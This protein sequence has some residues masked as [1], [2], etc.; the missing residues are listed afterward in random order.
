L[1]TNPLIEVIF[2]GLCLSLKDYLKKNN[3]DKV[4]LGLSGGIDSAVVAVI[5]SRVCKNVSAIMMPTEFTTQ[6]SLVN[7]KTLASNLKIAYK[8]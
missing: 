5:A 2:N 8:I 6:D 1:Q 7:A 4:I 3:I